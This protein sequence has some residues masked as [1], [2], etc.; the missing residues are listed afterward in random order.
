MDE[1]TVAVTVNVPVAVFPACAAANDDAKSNI[2]IVAMVY[3]TSFFI[4]VPLS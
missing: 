4:V 3:M 1:F 2:A